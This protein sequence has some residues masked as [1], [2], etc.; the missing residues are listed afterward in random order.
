[1]FGGFMMLRIT[2]CWSLHN[3]T[4]SLEKNYLLIIVGMLTIGKDQKGETISHCF[5]G[6][7]A[8]AQYAWYVLLGAKLT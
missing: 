2:N 5:T 6:S 8:A 4:L 1:M 7:I 3:E